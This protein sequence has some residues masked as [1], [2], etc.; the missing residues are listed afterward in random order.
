MVPPAS[1]ADLNQPTRRGPSRPPSPAVNDAGDVSSTE[2]EDEDDDASAANQE[3]PRQNR[4]QL[5]PDRVSRLRIEHQ[6]LSR[7]QSPSTI[8]NLPFA[9]SDVKTAGD[10]L[11]DT[12]QVASHDE[13]YK[14]ELKEWRRLTGVDI[15]VVMRRR[16]EAGYGLDDVR[17]PCSSA[18]T[19]APRKRCIRNTTAS[20]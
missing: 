13:A 7:S 20:I 19:T 8:R 2:D 1:L 4:F 16:V 14:K 11:H 6:T 9:S 17:S 12:R 18:L 15:G 5:A 3:I 10:G